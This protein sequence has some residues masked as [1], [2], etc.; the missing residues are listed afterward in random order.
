MRPKALFSAVGNISHPLPTHIHT[1]HDPQDLPTQNVVTTHIHTTHGSVW[2]L[3]GIWYASQ[4]FSLPAAV[5]S[6][7]EHTMLLSVTPAVHHTTPKAMA[8]CAWVFVLLICPS[9]SRGAEPTRTA[10]APFVVA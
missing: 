6:T 4:P 5:Q 3:L 9:I 8:G 2:I 1:P 7:P 10:F